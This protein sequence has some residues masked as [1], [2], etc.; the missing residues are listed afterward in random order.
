MINQLIKE[1]TCEKLDKLFMN[2]DKRLKVFSLPWHCAHQ[3]ELLKLP[4]NWYYLINHTRQWSDQARPLNDKVKWVLHYEPGKYDL[5]LLHVDQQC[6]LPEF[7]KTKL[8]KEVKSQIKDIPIIVINHGTPVYPERFMIQAEMAG[9]KPTEKEG[10]KWAVKEMAKLLEG[11]SKIVCNSYEAKKMWGFGDWSQVILHG[12]D[13][14][15]W[16]DL[17]K[18]PR[19]VTFISPS[20]I[21]DKYYG[22]RLFADTRTTLREKYGIELVLIASDKHCSNWDDYRSFIGKSLVY[23]N[24]TFGSPN[25][26]TR[27]EAM[28]SG[29]CVVTTKHQDAD[30]WFKDSVNGFLVNDNPE[31]AAKV[32]AERIF[33][34]KGSVKVGQEGKKTAI[35]LFNGDRFRSDWI[36][37]IEG[38]LGRKV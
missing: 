11:V 34:Y 4:F 23:F 6:L 28:M 3:Y 26:R 32:L 17:T 25:P 9:Y 29:C 31:E 8:F 38:V 20:G 7:G 10:E 5:A 18:E 19:I 35:K 15:E 13:P 14:E 24:P 33:D 2:T 22:R 12:I 27:L 1:E 16:W 30:K 36:R 37:L 21:G